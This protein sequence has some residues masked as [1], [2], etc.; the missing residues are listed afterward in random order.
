[1]VFNTHKNI[2][3]IFS[4]KM[5]VFEY[6][7]HKNQAKLHLFEKKHIFIVMYINTKTTG[8]QHYIITLTSAFVLYVKYGGL[9]GRVG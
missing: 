8:S 6:L 3:F 4:N 1:M 9:Q 2:V 7:I 5:L